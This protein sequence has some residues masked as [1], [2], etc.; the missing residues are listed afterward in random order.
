M[1]RISFALALVTASALLGAACTVHQT[2]APGLTGPSEFAVSLSVTATPDS[3]T[4]DGR[5]NSMIVIQARDESG[6]ALANVP[7]RLD[8]LVDGQLGDYGV[9]STRNVVTGT[10]GRATAVYTAPPA[11]LPGSSVGA[12]NGGFASATAAGRC[13]EIVATS[14]GNDY[15][16]AQSR[17]VQIHLIQS[18]V[19]V[20][21]SG[22]PAPSFTVAPTSAVANEAVQFDGSKS[23]GGTV[24]GAGACPAGSPNITSYA[25][26]FGDGAT[27]SG[28]LASH[29][30]ARQQTYLV[31]LTVTNDLGIT[32]STT[33][34]VQVGAGAVPTPAFI[35]SPTAPSP[36]TSVS[37]DATTSKPGAG[38]SIVR[39]VWNWGDGSAVTDATS[40]AASHTFTAEGTYVVT[41]TVAD[42]SGQTASVTGQVKVAVPA[43]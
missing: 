3:I 10:D 41:L 17:R 32:G 14:I 38:H 43:P 18:G 2:E 36:G 1:K 28:R 27:A 8:M 19:I 21:A 12:C 7:F 4:Q 31:T 9:L 30:F 40:P 11:P 39:Y 6:R 26:N 37:F 42:E 35:S 33:L 15:S 23:C 29:A 24:D 20:P 5:S 25:W 34:S 13:V 16:A 22:T